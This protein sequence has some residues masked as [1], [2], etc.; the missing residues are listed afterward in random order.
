MT[1]PGSNA[2]AGFDAAEQALLGELADR[3]LVARGGFTAFLEWAGQYAERG[4]AFL[5]PE[6]REALHARARAALAWA[7]QR[8]T[9]GMDRPP[10]GRAAP[11]R[12]Y[13]LLAA[14]S[15]AVTGAAGL[16]GV[17][18]DLPT[19]TLLVLRSLAA[20]ARARGLNIRAADVQTA[21]LEA[22]TFGGPTDE[23]DDADLAFWSARAAVPVL[24]DM[25]PQVAA[26][27]S[28]RLALMLP[29]RAVP[30]VAVAASA[31]VNWQFAGF[32]QEVGDILLA[33]LPLERLHGRTRV[34]ACFEAMVRERRGLFPGR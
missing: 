29:A 11:A 15:G 7:W 31:G 12:L 21:C 26:R 24:A 3:Y 22:F 4:L 20:I 8:A 9:T 25:L 30:L 19:S 32:F 14:G 34:R 18:A 1:P 17:L 5:P 33:L 16:P 10:T 6:W 28:A 23:D 13:R 2:C 27:L